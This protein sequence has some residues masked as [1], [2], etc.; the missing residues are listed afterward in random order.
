MLGHYVL[1]AI[2]HT[3]VCARARAHAHMIARAHASTHACTQRR[4]Y[5]S[6]NIPHHVHNATTQCTSQRTKSEI[7]AQAFKFVRVDPES[8]HQDGKGIVAAW[9][10]PRD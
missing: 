3:H 1:I 9:L 8:G 2:V 6:N 7:H 4:G 10:Q 5:T